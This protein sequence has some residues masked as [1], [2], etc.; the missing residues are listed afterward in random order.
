MNL[1]NIILILIL[2][3]ILTETYSQEKGSVFLSVFPKDAVIKL[4]DNILKSHETYP[5][6]TGNYQIK[7]WAPT[8]EYVERNVN[9]KS[10]QI[11]RLHEVLSYSE[12]YKNYKK[13]KRMYSIGKGF[14]RYVSPVIFVF[15]VKNSFS[16]WNDLE[17]KVNKNYDLAVTAKN[18]YENATSQ[19]NIS[20]YKNIYNGYKN[21][22][23]ESLDNYNSSRKNRII[24]GSALLFTTVAFE[25]LSFKLKKPEYKEKVLLSSFGFNNINN[26]YSPS[27]SLTYKFN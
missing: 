19:S 12:D 5:L 17:N 8:R 26:Q 22:Y 25:Y 11:N 4:N 9:I 2:T 24:V 23:E 13:S 15:F 1:K 16:T 27:I 7:M 21:S 3:F 20:F 10:G 6:D 18:D 14:M